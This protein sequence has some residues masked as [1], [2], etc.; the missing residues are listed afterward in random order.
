MKETA[1]GAH[2]ETASSHFQRSR[3][4]LPAVCSLTHVIKCIVVEVQALSSGRI[5]T[6][7]LKSPLILSSVTVEPISPLEFFGLGTQIQ[8]ERPGRLSLL[9]QPDEGLTGL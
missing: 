4:P 6:A 7:G 9:R 5:E 1:T 8:L 3:R 2:A